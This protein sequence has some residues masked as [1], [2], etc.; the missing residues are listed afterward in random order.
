MN[1][2]NKM[3]ENF[4]V[5]GEHLDMTEDAADELLVNLFPDVTVDFLEEYEKEYNLV[6]TGTNQQRQNR[7]LSAMR[8]RGGLSKA[9]FENIGNVLGAGQYTVVITEGSGVFPFIVAPYSS[10]TSPTGTATLIPGEVTSGNGLDTCY[11]ITCTVTGV[12]SAPELEKL[13]LR[14][15]PAWTVWSFVYIP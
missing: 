5:I 15:Q 13:Y 11:H 6:S 7:I 14:L 1:S 3:Q 9:Y 2:M 8:Q 12:A 10:N 4:A